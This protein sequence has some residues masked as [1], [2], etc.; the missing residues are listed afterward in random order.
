[1]TL[2]CSGSATT[3]AATALFLAFRLVEDYN[4]PNKVSSPSTSTNKPTAAS[5]F[6]NDYD[7]RTLLSH[8]IQVYDVTSP[9]TYHQSRFFKHDSRL[10]M[11]AR[12]DDGA[13]AKK[14]RQE[15]NPI[16]PT[17]LLEG[18]GHG[19]D[20][21]YVQ[22]NPDVLERTYD[23]D[24]H[25]VFGVLCGTGLIERFKIYRHKKILPSFADNEE[26]NVAKSQFRTEDDVA[27]EKSVKLKSSVFTQ[28]L[29]VVDIKLGRRLNGHGG[30]VHG[31]IISL[32]FDEA[33]GWACECLRLNLVEN[34]ARYEEQHTK[35]TIVTANLNINFRAP[36]Y[37]D[38]KAVV[39]VFHK[40][41]EGRKISLLARLESHDGKT[42]YAE[43]E[44]L[45]IIVH[46]KFIKNTGKRT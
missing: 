23:R 45:F 4:F 3:A 15:E 46:Q 13:S 28:E 32:L 8:K 7:T 42:I 19:T 22:M 9:L 20:F 10:K 29:T 26:K 44:S 24:S 36:L 17:N 14:G 41:T 21:Y 37:E 38:S 40:C 43:A 25:A 12:C 34:N 27:A 16:P 5:Q 6:V 31:G 11:T 33:M 39:R 1:M 18:A 2:N 35:S 30:I